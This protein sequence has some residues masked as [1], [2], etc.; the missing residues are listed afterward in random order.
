MNYICQF[1]ILD[2]SYA[3]MMNEKAHNSSLDGHPLRGQL[4]A[5]R[6]HAS[7]LPVYTN[8]FG[9]TLEQVIIWGNKSLSLEL[10]SHSR[11]WDAAI[12]GHLLCARFKEKGALDDYSRAVSAY[13]LAITL[14]LMGHPKRFA[15]L[16][17]LGSILQEGY[18]WIGYRREL[19]RPNNL[20]KETVNGI[21]EDDPKR[22]GGRRGQT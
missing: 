12:F 3:I 10:S 5:T 20:H 1:I 13:E 14:S 8:W 7:W 21:V 15:Y 6:C 16:D 22:R 19:D 4:H 18:E 11:A 9:Q 2:I 17:K